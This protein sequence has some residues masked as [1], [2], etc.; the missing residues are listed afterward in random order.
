MINC[1]VI[2][3]KFRREENFSDHLKTQQKILQYDLTANGRCDQ[4]GE[5]ICTFMLFSVYVCC[6]IWMAIKF[7]NYSEN[8]AIC[9]TG[10]ICTLF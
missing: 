7:V 1:H 10:H 2:F 6:K 4:C 8:M 9:Q 3:F 5:S